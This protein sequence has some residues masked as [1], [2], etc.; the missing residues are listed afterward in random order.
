MIDELDIL[1]EELGDR[2]LAILMP[3]K[4]IGNFDRRKK[5][6]SNLNWCFASINCFPEFD[7]MLSSI[8]K[9]LNIAIALAMGIAYYYCYKEKFFREFQHRGVIIANKKEIDHPYSY[10][11]D[12][13]FNYFYP[14]SNTLASCLRLFM[15]KNVKKIYLFGADGYAKDELYYKNWKEFDNTL[16]HRNMINQDTARFNK[17]FPYGKTE[18]INVSA[19]SRYTPFKKINYSELL[20]SKTTKG[21]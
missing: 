18:I 6:F 15:K 5:E 17:T 7:K 4:S 11:L 14:E 13:Y 16:E 12:R 3:G 20:G 10:K 9:R 1:D 2:P 8:G 19:R 21:K